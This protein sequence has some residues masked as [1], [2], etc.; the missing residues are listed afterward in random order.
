[1]NEIQKIILNFIAL[2]FGILLIIW[3][4]LQF[5]IYYKTPKNKRFNFRIH[6][7]LACFLILIGLADFSKSFNSL[8]SLLKNY[9]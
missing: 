9:F 7:R 8:Y 1:M 3:S 6:F 5:K 4:L 2:I